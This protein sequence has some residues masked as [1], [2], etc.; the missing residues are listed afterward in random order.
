MKNFDNGCV[1]SPRVTGR[2]RSRLG[3]AFDRRWERSRY[4]DNRWAAPRWVEDGLSS[5][6]AETPRSRTVAFSR[7]LWRSGMPASVTPADDD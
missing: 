5:E 4:G 3:A 1:S 2:L 6:R 7:P